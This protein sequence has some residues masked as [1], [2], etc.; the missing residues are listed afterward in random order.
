MK[1]YRYTQHSVTPTTDFNMST[2][3][4]A[5]YTFIR[6]LHTQQWTKLLDRTQG[7]NLLSHNRNKSTNTLCNMSSEIFG[8]CDE[9]YPCKLRKVY[10]INR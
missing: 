5:F 1:K 3:V 6:Q 9:A 4:P 7:M 2:L 8:G 10:K